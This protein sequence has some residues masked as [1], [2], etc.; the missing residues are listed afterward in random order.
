V[1]L[2]EDL[3]FINP[4]QGRLTLNTTRKPSSNERLL[5][6]VQIQTGVIC[7]KSTELRIAEKP[8]EYE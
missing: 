1:A 5:V 4:P 8:A 6:S 7:L 2:A 3:I